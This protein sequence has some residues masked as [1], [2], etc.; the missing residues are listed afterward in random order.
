MSSPDAA[1]PKQRMRGNR[2]AYTPETLLSVAV[3]VF[4]ERGYDGTSMADLATAA[5]LS[6]SSIYHHV[7]GKEELLALALDRALDA[8]FAVLAHPAATTGPAV[9]RLTQVVRGTVNA[10]IDELPYVTLL[11]RV[12]GNSP[13]E[14]SALTRRRRFDQ[15]VATLVHDAQQQG[16]VAA[17]VDAAIATRLIF[18]MINSLTEWYRPGRAE[19]P[20]LPETVVRL[21][22]SGLAP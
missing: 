20:D 1:A 10:L 18:G 6:K 12:R 13:T 11:L 3:T 5:G 8:L 22:R 21:V 17:E 15:L 2:P 14:L 19:L 7:Q 4:T 16:D 9:D